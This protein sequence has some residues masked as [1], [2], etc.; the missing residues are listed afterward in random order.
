MKH[1][2]LNHPAGKKQFEEVWN[3]QDGLDQEKFNPRTFFFLHGKLLYQHSLQ[4]CKSKI[5]VQDTNG[6]QHLDPLE[7][8]ALFYSEIQK[9][10][11]DDAKGIE[12]HED[13]ARMREHAVAEVCVCVL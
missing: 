3:V 1:Q 5:L 13:M 7:M 10:Y 6:D 11:G 9:V 12:A 8:E 4:L 2:K